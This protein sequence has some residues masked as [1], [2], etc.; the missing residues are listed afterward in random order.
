VDTTNE[1]LQALSD[2]LGVKALPAFKFY[3]NGKEVVDQVCVCVC[4]CVCAC[5]CACACVRVCVCVCVCAWV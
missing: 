2:E 1:E 5:A 4:V 3:R